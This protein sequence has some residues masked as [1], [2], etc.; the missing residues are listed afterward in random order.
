MGKALASLRDEGVLIIGSGNL[1]CIMQCVRN[2][3]SLVWPVLLYTGS[4]FHSMPDRIFKD[5]DRCA[6]SCV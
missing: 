6:L 3:S 5:G 1:T 4:S 2:A